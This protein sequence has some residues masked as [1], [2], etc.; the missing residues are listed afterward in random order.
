MSFGFGLC[1]PPIN[2]YFRTL[3]IF[4]FSF[5]FGLFFYC[6]LCTCVKKVNRTSTI[7]TYYI[8]KRKT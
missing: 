7:Q 3:T 5:G 8:V 2:Y 6:A 1:I 4:T